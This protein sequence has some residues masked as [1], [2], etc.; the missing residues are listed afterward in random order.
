M[1]YPY[2]FKDAGFDFTFISPPHL[3]VPVTFS[4][5]RGACL[6]DLPWPLWGTRAMQINKESKTVGAAGGIRT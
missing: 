3:I 6:A 1:P 5:G 4:S 2:G